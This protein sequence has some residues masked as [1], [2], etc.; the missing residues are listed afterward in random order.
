MCVEQHGGIVG[1]D[2]L[3]RGRVAYLRIQQVDGAVGGVGVRGRRRA[4]VHARIWSAVV[5]TTPSSVLPADAAAVGEA[6]AC[7]EQTRVQIL[8]IAY[9]LEKFGRPVGCRYVVVGPI[10]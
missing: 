10:V 1:V 2:D 8:I 4:R 9:F 5:P 6:V 3:K 7:R